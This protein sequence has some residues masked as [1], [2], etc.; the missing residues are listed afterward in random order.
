M[1][2]DIREFNKRVLL[3]GAGF[4]RNWGGRLA[5]EMWEEIFSNPA[6]QRRPSLRT[7]LLRVP[8]FED[9]LAE[10]TD[11]KAYDEMPKIQSREIFDC[12]LAGN[13]NYV[14]LHGCFLW[15]PADGSPGMVLG[16]A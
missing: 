10:T 13:L 7:L 2:F 8:M 1:P 14:K 12:D 4:S 9:V 6:V 16:G 5:R 15:H 11:P 3:T